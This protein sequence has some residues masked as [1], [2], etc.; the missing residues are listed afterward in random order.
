MN[1]RDYLPI[2]A[3]VLVLVG[4]FFLV[5]PLGIW[6]VETTPRTFLRAT[7]DVDTYTIL[8]SD[9]IKECQESAEEFECNPVKLDEHRAFITRR[10]IIQG[11][12][13]NRDA[14]TIVGGDDGWRPGRMDL[15][16]ISFQAEIDK[17]LGTTLRPGHKINIYGFHTDS[18]ED[19]PAPVTLIADHVWVVDARTSA[20]GEVET[21]PAE[22]GD[23]AGGGAFGL[24]GLAE[25]RSGPASI[26]TVAAEPEIAL[27]IIRALG[28]QQYQ[29][30]VT[31]SGPASTGVT[32]TPPTPTP[33]PTPIPMEPPC[34]KLDPTV[35]VFQA[36]KGGVNP[37][38][39]KVQVNNLCAGTLEWKVTE[40]LAWL[41][42]APSSGTAGTDPSSFAVAVDIAGLDE[43]VHAGEMVVDGGPGTQNSPQAVG[44][45]LVI[46]PSTVT[47]PP[48][49]TPVKTDITA[50]ATPTLPTNTHTPTPSVTLEPPVVIHLFLQ[51]T[52]YKWQFDVVFDDGVSPVSVVSAEE[53]Q[54]AGEA[55]E[56][57]FHT[58][59]LTLTVTNVYAAQRD[60]WIVR[61]NEDER[62]NVDIQGHAKDEEGR[63]LFEWGEDGTVVIRL[64]DGA[65]EATVKLLDGV[66]DAESAGTA[67]MWQGRSI[68]NR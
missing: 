6:A 49:P 9:M 53:I 54:G 56:R 21:R 47:P 23:G 41:D 67:L 29:A 64:V 42:A 43:G 8:T 4:A 13:L 62:A 25:A 58:R 66:E 30:W 2:L 10:A 39:E 15:E 16:V 59:E 63:D 35:V 40:D 51:N 36:P 31:L 11:E 3:V 19:S 65:T 20:G 61:T 50:T 48:T 28:A 46:G 22:E 33:T 60:V 55:Y 7:Q 12:E 52:P 32:P 26:V 38:P 27:Q 44:V 68:P 45:V 57:D 37:I 18:E 1:L 34:L 5:D 14:Y 24:G 17:I